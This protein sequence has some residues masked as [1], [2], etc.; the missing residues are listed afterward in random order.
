MKHIL[1]QPGVMHRMTVSV[2]RSITRDFVMICVC[3]ML[4]FSASALVAEAASLRLSPNTGVYTAGGTITARVIIN[5]AGKP[6]NA[7]EGTLSFNP[8]E[9]TVV[10]VSRGG[11]IFNIWTQEPSFSNSAGT[12][13]FGGGSPSGYTGSAGTIMTI[14]FRAASAG[15]PKVQFTNGSVLAADGLGTNVLKNMTGASYTIAAQTATPEPEYIAPAHTPAAPKISS[16]THGD[17]DGW[18]TGTTASLSWS[19]PSDVVAVRTLLDASPG[20]IPTKV[21][22]TPIA[23][24]TIEDLD[25]GVSYFHLQFKNENGWGRVAH[26]RLAVDSENPSNFT[27]TQPDGSDPS[28]PIQQLVFT[29]T[30]ETSPVTR[31]M[32]QVDGADPVAFVDEQGDGV[33][34]LPA[35]T[36]GKHTVVV[37]AFDAAGNAIVGTHSFEIEAFDKPVFTD[38]PTRVNEGVIPVVLGHTRP[39]AAVT[40]TVHQIGGSATEY[41][42]VS[43]DA[44]VFT[45]IPDGALA[46][47]VYEFTAVAV[48]TYGAQSEAADLIRFAVEAPGY[49]QVGSMVISVLSIL[50]PLIAL[51]VLMIFGAWYLWHRLVLWRRRVRKEAREAEEILAKEFAVMMKNLSQNVTK[52]QKSQRGKLTKAETALI[53]QIS[54]D[55]ASAKARIKKEVQDTEKIIT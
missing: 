15:S 28:N 42:V 21:Y 36:P 50:V 32:V 31:F 4:F 29:V 24:I 26:Y 7:A 19:V 33:Y 54:E 12:I 41:Q 53:D 47:G 11:S 43:D 44:G 39:G 22:D 45:V 25:Q 48:D 8:R 46:T 27:I 9:L 37:E 20:T 14:T 30:D 23:G 49:I 16:D 5:T 34:T 6:V 10:N 35:L 2:L 40:V 55:V 18:H 17:A 52:L 3:I 1:V 38:Y 13:S 51:V